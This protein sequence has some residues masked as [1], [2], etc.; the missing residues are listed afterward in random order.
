LLLPLVEILSSYSFFLVFGVRVMLCSPDWPWI[1]NPPVLVFQVLGLQMCITTTGWRV[2]LFYKWQPSHI[3]KLLTIILRSS[4]QRQYEGGDKFDF[5][6]LKTLS[7]L[8]LRKGKI[9]NLMDISKIDYN[10]YSFP[11]FYVG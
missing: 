3:L 2:F 11:C 6:A 5:L 9:G 1:C 4:G 8:L 7:V 10:F